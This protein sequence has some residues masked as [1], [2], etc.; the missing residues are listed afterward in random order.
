MYGDSMAS[1]EDPLG[2]EQ[3]FAVN[4]R[5]FREQAGMTQAA[6]AEG[7]QDLGFAYVRQQTID[8]IEKL[9]Q[10]PRLGES[11]ALARVLGT[12]LATML[13]P[14]ELASDAWLALTAARDVRAAARAREDAALR[15]SNSRARL[16]Q[17][18]ARAEK[19]DAAELAPEIQLGRSALKDTED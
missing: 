17:A 4:L 6:I 11:H 15:L 8:R 13:Q 19:K 7:M 3:R 18:I 9:A 2:T 5:A 12:S 16:E 10:R 1:Q 14:A